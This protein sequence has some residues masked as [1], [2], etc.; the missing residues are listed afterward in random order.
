MAV[1]GAQ[2]VTVE[3]DPEPVI[4]EFGKPKSQP[5]AGEEVII[6]NEG[7][8]KENDEVFIKNEAFSIFGKMRVKPEDGSIVVAQPGAGRDDLSCKHFIV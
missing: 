4:V 8:S 7:Y 6:V 5:N 2:P 1:N 3:R